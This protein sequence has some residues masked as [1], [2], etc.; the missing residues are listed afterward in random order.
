M[1]GGVSNA[2]LGQIDVV[3]DDRWLGCIR[4]FMDKDHSNRNS[5]E[6]LSGAPVWAAYIKNGSNGTL[7][8]GTG[9]RCLATA[10]GQVIGHKSAADGRVDGV[11][12]PYIPAAGLPN[13]SYGWVIFGGPCKILAGYGGLA[14][15][16]V[17][18][19]AVDGTFITLTENNT[20]AVGRVGVAE[21]AISATATG[22]AWLHLRE[23]VWLPG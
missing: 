17:I 23:S 9:V 1:S 2:A 8:P 14:Q 5:S 3:K 22:R 19:T 21:E 12:D 18:Q 10:I 15:A 16:D 4:K 20:Y 11:I 13:G 7:L 6:L